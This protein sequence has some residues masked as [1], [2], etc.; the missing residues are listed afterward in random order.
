[1]LNKIAIISILSLSLI[2]SGC[3]TRQSVQIENLVT[4]QE[5]QQAEEA[6]AKAFDNASDHFSHGAYIRVANQGF[7]LKFDSP[8]ERN[9]TPVLLG[10]ASAI[11]CIC[12]L[13]IIPMCER[14]S[15]VHTSNIANISYETKYFDCI[16]W[17]PMKQE[18]KTISPEDLAHKN[19]DKILYDL[20]DQEYLSLDKVNR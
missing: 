5:K 6:I 2:M 7:N 10:V 4:P 1:M 15:T 3:A 11:A 16:G 19:V 17:L 9:D 20:F 14:R 18:S 8:K 12:T 13:G